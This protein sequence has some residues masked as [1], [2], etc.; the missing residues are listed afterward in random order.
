MIM[1]AKMMTDTEVRKGLNDWFDE[2]AA[3]QKPLDPVS[4]R[5]LMENL[6]DLYCDGSSDL[7]LPPTSETKD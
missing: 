4:H 1:L 3:R 7:K 6:W 5:I 2:F